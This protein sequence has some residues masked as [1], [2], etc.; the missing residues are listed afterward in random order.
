MI[1]PVKSATEELKKLIGA[2][3]EKI[4]AESGADASAL[5]KFTV[6]IPADKSHGDFATNAALASAK[7]L[8]SNPRK[9]AEGITANISLEGTSFEKVEIAGR[10]H[11][12]FPV[13]VMVRK[14]CNGYPQ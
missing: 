13:K 8:R 4:A 3:L 2:A 5:P 14:C 9:I 1:N 12:L 11:Q 6:E 10:L 7:A